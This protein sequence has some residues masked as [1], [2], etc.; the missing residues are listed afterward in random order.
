M[1]VLALHCGVEEFGDVFA[2]VGD[3]L[4]CV[5]AGRF[6][7]T[8]VLSFQFLVMS[9]QFD[10]HKRH[11]GHRV[12]RSALF[13]ECMFATNE[14]MIRTDVWVVKGG[15]LAVRVGVDKMHRMGEDGG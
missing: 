2:V 5:V 11:R 14:S 12:C 1:G 7:C 8:W 15:E 4:V 13:G 9:F 6:G 10:S 3:N